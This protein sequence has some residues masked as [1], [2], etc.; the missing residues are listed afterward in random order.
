MGTVYAIRPEI[1]R[2]GRQAPR[3]AHDA[4]AAVHDAGASEHPRA[5]RFLRS[6]IREKL[7]ER[8]SISGRITSR[9]VGPRGAASAQ[10]GRRGYNAQKKG[11]NFV[12]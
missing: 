4:G 9:M 11:G 8:P 12:K 6:S 2:A 7:K 5:A 3:W 1:A 10:A